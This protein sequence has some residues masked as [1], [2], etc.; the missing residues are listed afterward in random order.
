MVKIGPLEALFLQEGTWNH[1]GPTGP[2][3]RVCLLVGFGRFYPL[4]CDSDAKNR[5]RQA[6]ADLFPDRDYRDFQDI[7]RIAKFNNDPQTTIE[8]I[9][10]VCRKAGV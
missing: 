9:R 6:I 7:V 4:F 1:F 10:M 8:D 5:L 2:H 3:G